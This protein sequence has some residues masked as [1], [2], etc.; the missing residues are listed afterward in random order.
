[1]TAAALF[2]PAF[3]SS[4]YPL[5]AYPD[6]RRLILQS[7]TGGRSSD[8][9]HPVLLLHLVQGTLEA[10]A[11]SRFDD[12][13][14]RFGRSAKA[15]LLAPT[16]QEHKNRGRGVLPVEVEAQQDELEGPQYNLLHVEAPSCSVFDLL[17]PLCFL[18]L[19]Q[20]NKTR[21]PRS[22]LEL[23]PDHD[24]VRDHGLGAKMNRKTIQVFDKD[25]RRQRSQL[26]ESLRRLDQ[27]LFFD[28]ENLHSIAAWTVFA[29]L[30]NDY[31][32]A[33]TEGT[34][35]GKDEAILSAG[36]QTG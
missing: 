22:A 26:F 34:A 15:R 28:F 5:L 11:R 24:V 25:F 14:G 30:S 3:I 23:P 17:S 31:I 35:G 19:D 29:V 2:D 7:R 16:R 27:K 9:V 13:V 6:A 8:D 18:A 10:F 4:R 12:E 20:G 33:G 21:K 36:A 1:W 32:F